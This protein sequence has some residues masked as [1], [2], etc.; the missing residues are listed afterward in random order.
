MQGRGNVAPSGAVPLA[1]ATL[2]LTEK[3]DTKFEFSVAAF[4]EDDGP[5]TFLFRAES[6]EDRTDW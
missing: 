6:I 1:G 2:S 5:R 3:S 4:I